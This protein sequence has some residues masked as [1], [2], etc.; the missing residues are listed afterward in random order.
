MLL[1][2]LKKTFAED[3]MSSLHN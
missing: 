2:Q 3:F 1:H